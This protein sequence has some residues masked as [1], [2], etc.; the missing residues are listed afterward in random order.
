M[1]TRFLLLA[2]LALNSLFAWTSLQMW[3]Y[4]MQ[5]VPFD[6]EQVRREFTNEARQFVMHSCIAGTNYPPEFRQ[7][8]GGGWN[9]NSPAN[10]CAS[11]R[12]EIY[13][14]W[15]EE[16]AGRLGRKK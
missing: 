4:Y 15:I 9:D 2:A 11:R 8:N 3:A 10:W 13:N 1:L 14:E 5:T 7:S 6:M 16:S 12:D